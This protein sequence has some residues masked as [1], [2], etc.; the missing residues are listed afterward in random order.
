MRI[1][2][3]QVL[4]MQEGLSR[5]ILSTSDH[6]I[7]NLPMLQDEDEKP[8]WEVELKVNGIDFNPE[9]FNSTFSETEEWINYKAE[10]KFKSDLEDELIEAKRKIRTLTE[11]LEEVI[12]NLYE[13]YEIEE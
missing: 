4:K 12:R 10:Q 13:K 8:Y 7:Y 1:Y 3:D 9:I 2:F 11:T 6:A 5:E